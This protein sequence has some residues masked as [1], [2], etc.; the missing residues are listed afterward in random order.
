LK[1][2]TKPSDEGTEGLEVRWVENLVKKNIGGT[3]D[4]REIK[5]KDLLLLE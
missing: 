3:S 2:T 1:G 5:T 4:F